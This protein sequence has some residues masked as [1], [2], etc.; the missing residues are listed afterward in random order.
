MVKNQN[1]SDFNQRKYDK[2]LLKLN[3]YKEVI[4]TF[5]LQ[6][7]IDFLFEITC[8]ICENFNYMDI[9]NIRNQFR[10]F[11]TNNFG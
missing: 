3:K 5:D 11:F 2:I 9:N 1:H 8:L 10:I 7:I 6:K 4:T